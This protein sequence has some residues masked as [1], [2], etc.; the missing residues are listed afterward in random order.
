MDAMIEKYSSLVT[1][2]SYTYPLIFWKPH[3]NSL[4][5]LAPLAKKFLGVSASSA[6]VERMFNISGHVHSSKRRRTG[7]KLFENLVFL[8]L[9]EAYL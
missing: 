5:I 1:S 8:K 3:E 9:N 7:V 4:P 2:S 6:S